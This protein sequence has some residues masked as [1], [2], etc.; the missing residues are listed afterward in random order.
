MSFSALA[1]A[2]KQD[3]KSPISKLVLL[4][5]A[6]Y[7][8][9]YNEAYPSQQHLAK[10][11]QCT[12]VSIN[13]H[14]KDLNKLGLITTK[15]QKNNMYGYNLYVLNIKSVNN[16]DTPNVN[17]IDLT[18]KQILHNTQDTHNSLFEHFWNKCPRKIGKK[19]VKSIYTN[20]VAKKE[21]TQNQLITAMQRYADSVKDTDTAFIAH[22][23]TWL[24]QGR[25]EDKIE[26]KK[27]N[28]NYLLG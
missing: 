7:A 20:L 10:L 1:W 16:I 17:N 18:S 9:E 13:K 21:V 23:T 19:K 8:N 3:T 24:N 4:M 26:Y 2:V 12:R 6:N 25:W 14:I 11:C 5:I 22:P 28:K 27:K 15:K